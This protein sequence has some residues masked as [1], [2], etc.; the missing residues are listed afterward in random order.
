MIREFKLGDYL[1]L[2]PNGHS[3]LSEIFDVF[4]D[5]SFKKFTLDDNGNITCIIIWKQ[6]LPRHY[7]IAFLMEEVTSFAHARV[8]KKFMNTAIL[9]TNPRTCITH[10]FD[11]DMLNR[12]HRFFGFKKQR[13][14]LSDTKSGFNTW[15][16]K[17]V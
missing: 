17:W 2:E 6:Y 12:W 3:K 14:S 13:K 4:F 10:S 15:L 9:G 8:L 11:C 16:I 5:D 1:E 7:A